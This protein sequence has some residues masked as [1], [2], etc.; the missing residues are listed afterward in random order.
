MKYEILFTDKNTEIVDHKTMENIVY[1]LASFKRSDVSQIH[2]YDE[3][4]PN[5]VGKT[6]WTEE[7]GLFTSDGEE[8]KTIKVYICFDRYGRDEWY[9]VF[10]ISTDRD[11]SIR[12]CTEEALPD[13]LNSGPDDNHSFQ[14]VE[15]EMSKKDYDR[16]LKWDNDPNQK[17]ENYGDQ[18]SDYFNWMCELYDRIGWVDPQYQ[19]LISTDGDSDYPE[20]VR[21]YSV[22]YKNQDV[23][24]VSEYDWLF[25]DEYE[26]YYDELMNDD[27]LR[28][29][30]IREYVRDT[31]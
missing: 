17:L 4:K 27:D 1:E 23:N 15:V 19:I 26:E 18:S 7:G 13:F 6:I 28:E 10:F 31:Y 24:E 2:E 5:K 29:K 30:V 9:N 21:Y 14:L 11:K 25:T 3:S 22:Y 12:K 8:Y 16:L 20:I